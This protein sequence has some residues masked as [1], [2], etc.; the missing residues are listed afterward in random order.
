M[1]SGTP[2][3]R[4]SE[5]GRARLPAGL[6]QVALDARWNHT[7]CSASGHGSPNADTRLPITDE[8]YCEFAREL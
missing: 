1:T 3:P 2:M 4:I 6:R 5:P 8:S 7:H